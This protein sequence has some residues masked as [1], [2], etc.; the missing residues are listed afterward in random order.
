MKLQDFVKSSLVDI[1]QGV[2]DAQE[3]IGESATINP[4]RRGAAAS[5]IGVVDG[6]SVQSIKFDVAV[7]TSEGAEGKAGAGLFVAGVGLGAKGSVSAGNSAI[8]R[9]KFQVPVTLPKMRPD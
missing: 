3:E 4:R 8:S 5:N 9:V 2:K 1:A 6:R 7:T